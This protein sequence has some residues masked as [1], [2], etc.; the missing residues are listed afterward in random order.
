MFLLYKNK[1]ER[2]DAISGIIIMILIPYLWIE[3]REE[4]SDTAQAAM[5]KPPLSSLYAVFRQKN[6]RTEYEAAGIYC[7]RGSYLKGQMSLMI[8]NLFSWDWTSFNIIEDNLLCVSRESAYI[9]FF[10]VTSTLHTQTTPA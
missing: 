5:A 10:I 2:K 3:K 6:P 1:N 9:C 4:V 7:W 8:S